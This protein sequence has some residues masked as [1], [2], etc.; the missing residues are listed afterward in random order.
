[1]P[2]SFPDFVPRSLQMDAWWMNAERQAGGGTHRASGPD[3]SDA[4]PSRH[5]WAIL[6][7]LVLADWLLWDVSPGLSAVL[8]AAAV[9]ITR[10]VLTGSPRGLS[11]FVVLLI[12]ALPML[13]ASGPLS[14]LFLLAGTLAA[15]LRI[16]GVARHHILN[17]LRQLVTKAAGWIV[18]DVVRLSQ[19]A[20]DR[21]HL[22]RLVASMAIPL[23]V[24][25]VFALLFLAANPVLEHGADSLWS[26]LLRLDLHPL[27]LVFWLALL[28]AL[29]PL[30][31]P[32]FGAMKSTRFPAPAAP[33]WLNAHLLQTTLIMLNT[34]FALQTL[35]DLTYL[36]GGAELPD[37]MTY[38]T[39]AHRGAYPLLGTTI[40]SGALMLTATMFGPL[41]TGIRR[42]LCVWVAQNLLLTVSAALRLNLY[43]EVYQLT[44]LRLSA[45]IWMAL[46][47]VIFALILWRVVRSQSNIWIV[48][49]IAAAIAMTLYGSSFINY[50]AV[51][52]SYNIS[53]SF[54][55]T[56]QGQPLDLAY[57]CGLGPEA[58][59]AARSY[60]QIMV[61][62]VSGY[63][64]RSGVW[65]AG[66]A[67]VSP[68]WREW[69]F[70][71]WRLR[72][73]LAAQTQSQ[74]PT[75]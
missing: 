56:G 72:R 36:W 7:L 49:R 10:A 67:E 9:I 69:G 13:E 45:L 22:A 27:R 4:P 34:L 59:A 15:L 21:L 65:R 47:A 71:N 14:W 32:H 33:A 68:N 41:T 60:P 57:L 29:W 16:E 73:Y 70:R 3:L 5:L 58:Y 17:A 62:C 75:E 55:V 31:T 43:V 51:I 38:A 24:T 26:A 25:L 23:G 74:G 64:T 46:V 11:A 66:S 2:H 48:A 6:A 20:Q 19:A 44:Y 53:H 8:F 18:S 50:P 39:Y 12:A 61:P 63:P 54:E 52:A 28:L 1:M 37:G 42:L 40:L 35:L 30:I